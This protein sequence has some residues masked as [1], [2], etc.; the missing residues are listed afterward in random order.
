MSEREDVPR[1]LMARVRRARAEAER[2]TT[3]SAVL[4]T[5]RRALADPHTMVRRCAW[6]NR[7]LLG[8][9]WVPEDEVPDFVGDLLENRTTHGI[10][11]NCVH[12]L[13]E[14]GESRRRT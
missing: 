6:C 11:E 3:R 7:L 14:K 8:R 13:E 5:A 9:V 4:V 1:V 12:E 2:L 10:C